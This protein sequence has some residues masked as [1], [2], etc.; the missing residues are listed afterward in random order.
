MTDDEAMRAAAGDD[1][2]AFAV[3]FDRH[4]AAVH[5]FLERRLGRG[6]AD[7]R[8]ADV[9]RIAFEARGRFRPEGDG[10]LPWLYGI[11]TNVVARHRRREA[12]RLRALARLGGMRDASGDELERVR[13]ALS[14]AADARRVADALRRL[15]DADRD[16]LLLVAWEGLDYAQAARALDVPVGT[17]RSR[18]NRARGRLR[19][20]LGADGEE[21]STIDPETTEGRL[22]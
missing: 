22:T 19:E 17:V 15:A 11:A 14:A 13:D 12:R 1:P 2:A 18:I 10:A 7:D 4:F 6:E 3:I 21:G 5:G 20:L 8:A 9:F 16:T